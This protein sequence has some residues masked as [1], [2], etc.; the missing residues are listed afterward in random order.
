MNTIQSFKDTSSIINELQHDT[1]FWD[2]YTKKE[3]Y[4]QHHLD[5][6]G[7]Y[8]YSGRLNQTSLEPRVSQFLQ[9]KGFD[10]EYPD[11]KNFAILLTHD[12]DDIYITPRHVLY[13]I[14]HVP[15]NKD[16]FFPL[17]LCVG[18]VNKEKINYKSFANIM[19][20]ENKY[21]T[22]SSFFFLPSPEDVF[23]EKYRLDELEYEIGTILDNGGE[24][25]FH[26]GYYM[27]DNIK[28]IQNQ[29]RNMERFIGRKI[30]GAR[31]HVLRFTTPDSWEILSDAGFS[32]DS[33][34]GYHN[35]IGF[36]NGM[37]HPFRPFNRDTGKTIDILEIPLNVQDWT[38]HMEMNTHI[39]DAWHYI[40]RLIDVVEKYHGALTVLWH[41]WTFSFP[42][43]FGGIFSKEWNVLYEKILHYA[44][45]KNAWITNCQEF[46]KYWN[47]A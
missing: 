18:L 22:T 25:G 24:I 5:K 31:N 26:T 40:K 29:K 17:Y 19:E 11:K 34:Y 32:Y 7:R 47:E 16:I 21:G 9:Q 15:F 39:D 46:Y 27:Y 35:M 41:T 45:E 1:A 13:S 28:E 38:L 8:S 43:S 20:I 37:C 23:G 30:I 10:V 33:T 14:Y 36:R 6:Y 2:E 3:E 12:V 4:H 42:V 44:S